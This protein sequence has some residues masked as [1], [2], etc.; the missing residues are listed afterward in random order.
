M[1]VDSSK[2]SETDPQ[3]P[4]SP[5]ARIRLR[6]RRDRS[7]EVYECRPHPVPPLP[8]PLSGRGTTPPRAA[9]SG[10]VS[11]CGSHDWLP[12]TNED[13]AR[14]EA[15]LIDLRVEQLAKRYGI[16]KY[17]AYQQLLFTP[18]GLRL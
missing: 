10:S 3:G 4:P 2:V 12:D 16:S 9:P 1:T 15:D 14:G 6:L 13:P 17:A 11:V 5:P 7:G 18:E 8:Y